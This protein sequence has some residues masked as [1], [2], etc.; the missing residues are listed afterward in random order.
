SIYTLYLHDALPIFNDAFVGSIA[1]NY[2]KTF[3]SNVIKYNKGNY[4][5]KDVVENNPHLPPKIL[6][7]LKKYENQSLPKISMI[8]DNA[9][10]VRSEEHTSEL[11][12]REK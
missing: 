4:K 11:Q 5:V 10:I 9:V 7:K 1:G 3:L 8:G 2:S 6:A 12:S